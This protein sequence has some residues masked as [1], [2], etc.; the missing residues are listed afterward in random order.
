MITSHLV[1]QNNETTI[2]E[3]LNSI[4]SFSHQILIADIGSSDKTPEICKK[5]HA[6]VIK[7]SLNND[8]SQVRNNLLKHSKNEL[9]FWIEP[10]E[11][12]IQWENY[13]ETVRCNIIN[14]TNIHKSIRFWKNLKFRNPVYETLKGNAKNSEIYIKTNFIDNNE[15]NL[16][17]IKSWQE[18]SPLALE[19][20]YYL[21]CILLSQ[22]KWKEFINI[23]NYFIFQEKRQTM[24]VIMTKYYLSGVYF[25]IEKDYQKAINLLMNCIILKPLMA[26]FWCLLGDI[27]YELDK[28]DK[29]ICFY[30][31][32]IILGSRRLNSDEWPF[33]ITKYKNYP[34]TMIENCK[35]IKNS[36][37]TIY[38][39]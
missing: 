7:L 25:H 22:N 5:Y 28:Y 32:A 10:W 4:S 13:K 19:P 8:L 31:N 21:S 2:E 36:I 3:A 9:N 27:Y 17:L 1:I 34:E 37:K 6:E 16:R 26:E 14:G 39:I 35:K 23:A 29:A 20:Y 11:S 33:E 38:K 12:V 24:A 18:R 15:R 30:E